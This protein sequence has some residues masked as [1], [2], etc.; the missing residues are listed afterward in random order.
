MCAYKSLTAN[1]VSQV[2]DGQLTVEDDFRS[3]YRQAFHQQRVFS[4]LLSPYRSDY[5]I[6]LLLPGSSHLQLED[7]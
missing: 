7:L 5:T 1:N 4:E 3:G 2:L 6:I